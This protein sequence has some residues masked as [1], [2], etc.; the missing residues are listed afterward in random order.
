MLPPYRSALQGLFK[1]LKESQSCAANPGV[2][3]LKGLRCKC[4]VEG[5]SH[6]FVRVLRSS[7]G[8]S[9]ASADRFTWPSPGARGAAP[10]FGNWFFN[11]NEKL[12]WLRADTPSSLAMTEQKAGMLGIRSGWRCIA[13]PVSQEFLGAQRQHQTPSTSSSV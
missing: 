9:S 11:R 5:E 3:S 8:I 6:S 4:S 10:A 1:V 13:C 2:P 12:C 7:D